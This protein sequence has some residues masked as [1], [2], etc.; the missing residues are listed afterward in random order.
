ME[1]AVEPEQK[2]GRS[3]TELENE[4][5]NLFFKTKDQEAGFI[6]FAKEE[7]H[8]VQAFRLRHKFKVLDNAMRTNRDDI[9]L[10]WAGKYIRDND[11]QI[12]ETQ[13]RDAI[14]AKLLKY[15]TDK[16]FEKLIHSTRINYAY[17]IMFQLLC[18]F[19]EISPESCFTWLFRIK[20]ISA[21]LFLDAKNRAIH[22]KHT[23]ITSNYPLGLIPLYQYRLCTLDEIANFGLLDTTIFY[24]IAGC[25]TSFHVLDTKDPT[26]KG[27][28]ALPTL[29]LPPDLTFA[30]FLHMK[31]SI[32]I[33]T[34]RSVMQKCYAD[35][36]FERPFSFYAK[37]SQ[38]QL[39]PVFA[40]KSRKEIDEFLAQLRVDA[41]KKAYRTTTDGREL[42]DLGT[43][44]CSG[45]GLDY[46]NVKCETCDMKFCHKD[47]NTIHEC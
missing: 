26:Q 28:N 3:L 7:L 17:P 46:A 37:L 14:I 23:E 34:L 15:D 41:K 39:I 5:D 16:V 47:C 45:C 42:F 30:Y 24:G 40:N 2:K 27:F 22:T 25:P 43:P 11:I 4:A 10:H 12:A 44:I 19:L 32:Y 38:Y 13:N 18:S 36:L 9:W 31:Q 35:A 20:R 29:G 33:D 8:P 6:I 21:K 1:E